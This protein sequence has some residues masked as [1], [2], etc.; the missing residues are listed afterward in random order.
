MARPVIKLIHHAVP[1]V[2]EMD[3]NTDGTDGQNDPQ[4]SYGH[5]RP[6]QKPGTFLETVAPREKQPS[7]ECNDGKQNEQCNNL[8][9]ISFKNAIEIHIRSTSMINIEHELH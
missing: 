3:F 5:I 4:H 2:T 8:G 6:T 9:G 1:Q 7:K